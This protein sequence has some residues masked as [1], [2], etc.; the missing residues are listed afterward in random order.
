MAAMRKTMDLKPTVDTG[1]GRGVRTE[2]AKRGA[3]G[4]G[5]RAG[6]GVVGVGDR[7][8]VGIGEGRVRL[9]G[10][11]DGG[12]DV[13]RGGGLGLDGGGEVNLVHGGGGGVDLLGADGHCSCRVCVLCV[14]VKRSR[15]LLHYDVWLWG[16]WCEARGRV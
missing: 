3:D 4:D 16:Y 5:D 13:V 7:K 12:R 6:D 11:G 10:R 15:A 9:L 2:V 1:R 8:R 14:C